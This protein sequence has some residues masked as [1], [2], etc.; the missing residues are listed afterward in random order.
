MASRPA[1]LVLALLLL[2]VPLALAPPAAAHCPPTTKGYLF[3]LVSTCDANAA[4]EAGLGVAQA[5]ADHAVVLVKDFRF[6]PDVVR[7]KS[8]GTVVFV[9]ADTEHNAQHDPRSTGPCANPAVDPSATPELCVPSVASQLG[10]CFDQA[11]DDGAFMVF[12]GQQ[13]PLTLRYDAGSGLVQ[14]SRGYLSGSAVGDLT[15][16]QA[17]RTCAVGTGINAPA[18]TVIPYHCGI[19]GLAS[20]GGPREMRGAI[21]VEA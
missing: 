19:H 18:Q 14:K 13:Y 5:A 20:G 10:A 21:V 9:Y 17:F 6:H 2:A 15:G 3:Q 1:V 12:Y 4:A 16:A 7:V 11:K 8:G